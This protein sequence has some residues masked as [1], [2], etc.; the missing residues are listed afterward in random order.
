MDKLK[1][2]T[3]TLLKMSSIFQSGGSGQMLSQLQVS[4]GC[5]H[6]E[7]EGGGSTCEGTPRNQ[8]GPLGT[9]LS[10]SGVVVS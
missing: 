2:L 8:S 7:G 3:E 1:T 5:L 6:T 10:P 4:G 9:P